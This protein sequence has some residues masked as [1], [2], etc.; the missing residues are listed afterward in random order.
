MA[1]D[2]VETWRGQIRSITREA[3]S[4]SDPKVK[5]SKRSRIV[6]LLTDV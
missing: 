1:A 2:D 5:V 6:E 4:N 3:S